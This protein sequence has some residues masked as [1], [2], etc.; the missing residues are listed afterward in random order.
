MV[1][2]GAT[3]TVRRA[4]GGRASSV[5]STSCRA[6]SCGMAG[7]FSFSAFAM[8]C[9]LGRARDGRRGAWARRVGCE[10][11]RVSVSAFLPAFPSV[12]YLSGCREV[13][14]RI[15]LIA[16]QLWLCPYTHAHV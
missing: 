6:A 10:A 14:A 11:R 7:F 12:C 9:G 8:A 1:A 16:V 15:P 2:D 5:L 3:N 4:K 13:R